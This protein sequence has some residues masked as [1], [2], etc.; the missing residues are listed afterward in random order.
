[1]DVPSIDQLAARRHQL[2]QLEAELR[3]LENVG[4]EILAQVGEARGLLNAC[5]LDLLQ[6][7]LAL[8][9]AMDG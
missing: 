8:L 7:D 4:R 3:S 1:M 5:E 2:D 6:D 9:E